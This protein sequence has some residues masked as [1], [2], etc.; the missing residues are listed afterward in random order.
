MVPVTANRNASRQTVVDLVVAV[1]NGFVTVVTAAANLATGAK[2]RR[3]RHLTIICEGGWLSDRG[4]SNVFTTG[5]AI[6]VKTG[7][8]DTFR[9]KPALLEHEWRHSVQWAML[10]PV[11]FI[12]LYA[13]SYFASRRISGTQAWNVFEWTAGFSDGGYDDC[14]GFGK[15]KEFG[16]H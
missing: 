4:L 5:N 14:A 9:E 7:Y 1:A 13:L 15:R 16:E 2:V 3:D 11:R 12:P 8:E 10:G 6:N